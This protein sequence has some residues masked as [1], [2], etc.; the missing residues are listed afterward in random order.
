MM[1]LSMVKCG[2]QVVIRNISGKD[3][4]QKHLTQL[5]FLV[6]TSIT[7]VSTAAGHFIV[8]IKGSR[9]ALDKTMANRIHI[10]FKEAAR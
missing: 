9:I 3:E 2:E 1:P 10:S 5:G 6:D 7:V 4:V 8:Q